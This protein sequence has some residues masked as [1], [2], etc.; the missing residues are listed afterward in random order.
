M[1]DR[2]SQICSTANLT[3][4]DCDRLIK[5][6]NPSTFPGIYRRTTS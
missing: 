4:I 2:I 5:V 3:P 1:S 6:Y